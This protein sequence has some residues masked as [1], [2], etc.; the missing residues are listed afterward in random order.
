[1]GRR[2]V[3]LAVVIAAC[4]RQTPDRD[5][6]SEWRQVLQQKKTAVAA[7]AS[8]SQKQVYADSVAEFV[9]RHPDHGRAREVYHRLQ[10]EFADDLMAFGRFQDA[11]RFYRAV[12]TADPSNEAARKGLETALDRLAVTREKLE[13]LEKGM[14]H[15][16]VAGILGRP[17]PGWT[18]KSNRRGTAIEAW[19]YRTT[20]GSIA[21]VY[22][23][24]GAV[25]AAET[26]SD[27][28]L[29]L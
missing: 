29:G 20:T 23:R 8:L 15:R 6:Q 26:N 7:E 25:F 22:F 28:S 14:S 18:V 12:L 19:Y 16:Q 9:R 13:R 4:A 21:A 17:I 11:V 5:H 2:F 24:D 10:I 27:A 3:L 1:M